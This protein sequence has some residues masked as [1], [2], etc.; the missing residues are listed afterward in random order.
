MLRA[1]FS[2]GLR[3]LSETSARGW[4]RHPRQSGAETRQDEMAAEPRSS[5][6]EASSR[7]FAVV[8]RAAANLL[9]AALQNP[10]A[11]G[12][13]DGPRDLAKHEVYP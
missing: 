2:S 5:C 11:N 9:H 8:D 7:H 10:S 1:L 13:T 3:C 6:S 4:V 12:A